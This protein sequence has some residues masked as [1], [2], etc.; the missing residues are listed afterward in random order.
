M[1]QSKTVFNVSVLNQCSIIRSVQRK[2][3]LSF[4][5][6]LCWIINPCPVISTLFPVAIKTGWK[7]RKPSFCPVRKLPERKPWNF[8][9]QVG[10]CDG[11]QPFCPRQ[12]CNLIQNQ[13]SLK[14]DGILGSPLCRLSADTCMCEKNT[15]SDIDNWWLQRAINTQIHTWGGKCES[16]AKPAA[17]GSSL[18]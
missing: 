9:S 12:E 17:A 2:Y 4:M 13:A 3:L 1:V 15:V 14:N 11:I 10:H 8:C 16:R 5:T 6:S 7:Y 18:R